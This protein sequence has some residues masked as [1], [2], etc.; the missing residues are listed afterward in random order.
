MGGGVALTPGRLCWRT[1][2][3]EK[4]G[5]SR[6]APLCLGF[7]PCKMSSVGNSLW[8]LTTDYSWKIAQRKPQREASLER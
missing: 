3:K 8:A 5:S 1:G 2:S 7:P 6:K 4:G